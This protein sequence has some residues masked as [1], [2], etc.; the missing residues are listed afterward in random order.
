MASERC[1]DCLSVAQY[2]AAV[3]C[4][5]FK[6]SPEKLFFNVDLISFDNGFE[7]Y[8]VRIKPVACDPIVDLP[9]L[10]GKS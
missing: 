6:G 1:Q 2:V 7:R 9:I 5:V 10:T 4:C 3:K 8:G